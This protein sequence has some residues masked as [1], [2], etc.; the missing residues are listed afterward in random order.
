MN[1]LP[2]EPGN[3]NLR[4]YELISLG[5]GFLL[6]H[7]SSEHTRNLR[8]IGNERASVPS[9][10]LRGLHTKGEKQSSTSFS[11]LLGLNYVRRREGPQ[12]GGEKLAAKTIPTGC[13]LRR[14]TVVPGEPAL[15]AHRATRSSQDEERRCPRA[16]ACAQS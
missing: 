3:T 10:G 13:T 14:K 2:I 1:D 16:V 4:I 7:T 8:R 15:A 12:V 9:L 6:S 5:L 11:D